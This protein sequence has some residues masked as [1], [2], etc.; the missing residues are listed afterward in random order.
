MATGILLDAGSSNLTEE[1]GKEHY[2]VYRAWVYNNTVIG[3]TIKFGGSK[4]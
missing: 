3:K 2:Q 4:T 1:P